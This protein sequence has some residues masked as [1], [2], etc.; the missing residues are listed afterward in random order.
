MSHHPGPRFFHV[1]VSPSGTQPVLLRST[2]YRALL[3]MLSATLRDHPVRLV[4]YALLPARWELVVGPALSPTVMNLVAWVAATHTLRLQQI[5]RVRD[6]TPDASSFAIEPLA[7]GEELVR[8]CRSVERRA[9]E[10]QL[11]RRAEDWPWSSIAER[12]RLEPRLPLVSTRF[13]TSQTWIDLV[14]QP[15]APDSARPSLR[16]VPKKPRRLARCS[17]GPEQ[18]PRVAGI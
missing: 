17:Q 12:F 4:A 10:L 7:P 18:L 6:H 9:V 5:G 13:L 2:D 8:T 11:V 1:L 14:N 15:V 16:D 3:T